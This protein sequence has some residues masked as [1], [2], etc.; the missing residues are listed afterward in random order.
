MAYCALYGHLNLNALITKQG[1]TFLLRLKLYEQ[2]KKANPKIKH[3]IVLKKF[4]NYKNLLISKSV[5][6]T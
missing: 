3:E 1:L 5:S 6:Q 2:I 4:I